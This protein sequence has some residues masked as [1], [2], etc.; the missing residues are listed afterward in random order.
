[1]AELGLATHDFV[2][3]AAQPLMRCELTP[4]IVEAR[5]ACG[6]IILAF[7]A[8]YPSNA[9]VAPLWLRV[10]GQAQDK[11]VVEMSCEQRLMKKPLP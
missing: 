1:M 6:G 5:Y 8:E 2:G 10:L 7:L 9:C 11:D 4:D 3:Y